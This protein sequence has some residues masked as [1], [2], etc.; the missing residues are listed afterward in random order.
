MYWEYPTYWYK[1]PN[2]NDNFARYT[3]DNDERNWNYIE[4]KP[5]YINDHERY[6]EWQRA[7]RK[8][9]K[10]FR[11]WP[12]DF[13]EDGFRIVSPLPPRERGIRCGECGMQFE[14]GK[15][16]LMTCNRPRCPIFSQVSC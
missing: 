2:I 8:Y 4:H 1:K 5:N 11:D 6:G 9:T 12:D 10:M 3:H 7:F 16:I 15:A 13:D 14:A